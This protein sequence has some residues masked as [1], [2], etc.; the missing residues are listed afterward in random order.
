MDITEKANSQRV[1]IHE[2]ILRNID[3]RIKELY[4][5]RKK[6]KISR[7][8]GLGS[9]VVGVLAGAGSLYNFVEGLNNPDYIQA[10]TGALAVIPSAITAAIGGIIYHGAEKFIQEKDKALLELEGERKLEMGLLEG[11]RRL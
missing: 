7:A 10:V 5:E 9:L 4:G 2:E 1:E 3:G 8:A 6:L 11:A